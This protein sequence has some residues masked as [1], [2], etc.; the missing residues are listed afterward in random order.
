M[1]EEAKKNEVSKAQEMRTQLSVATNNYMKVI[2][3]QMDEGAANVLCLPWLQS[4]T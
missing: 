3:K 2:K 1:A 4:T